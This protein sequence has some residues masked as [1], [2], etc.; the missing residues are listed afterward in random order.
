MVLAMTAFLLSL[1]GIAVFPCWRYSARWGYAPAM[2]VA[3][4]LIGVVLGSVGGKARV[5]EN[6][7]ARHYTVQVAEVQRSFV[8]E[9]DGR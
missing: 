1:L 6:A 3:C 7:M 8:A 5:A 9:L 4:M 2:G